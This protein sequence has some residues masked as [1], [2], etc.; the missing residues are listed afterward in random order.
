MTLQYVNRLIRNINETIHIIIYKQNFDFF[1]HF[2][3]IYNGLL[4]GV[5]ARMRTGL[6]SRGFSVGAPVRTKLERCSGKTTSGHCRGTP[7]QGTKYTKAHIGPCNE[8]V[9]YP[10]VDPAVA[11]ICAPSS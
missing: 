6:R 9:T 1:F 5:V 3:R 4:R 8:V 11:P 7:E 2:Y 10:G